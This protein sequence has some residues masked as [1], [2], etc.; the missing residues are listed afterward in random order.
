M[1]SPG[2]SSRMDWRCHF[3]L[4]QEEVGKQSEVSRKKKRGGGNESSR[5][6]DEIGGKKIILWFS[7]AQCVHGRLSGVTWDLGCSLLEAPQLQKGYQSPQQDSLHG[8]AVDKQGW[9]QGRRDV[10]GVRPEHDVCHLCS[11]SMARIWSCGP[12]FTA[13]GVG[14]CGPLGS[15]ERRMGLPKPL[16]TVCCKSYCVLSSHCNI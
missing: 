10:L 16:G 7:S 9:T 12:N 6:Y 2:S 11:H 15:L 5:S 8:P 3:W 14:K 4:E 13:K 1:Q